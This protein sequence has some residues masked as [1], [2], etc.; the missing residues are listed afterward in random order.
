MKLYSLYFFSIIFLVACTEANNPNSNTTITSSDKVESSAFELNVPTSTDAAL[1][2]FYSSY[3]ANLNELLAAV[4][5]NDEAAIKT[6]YD[7]YDV[8]FDRIGA[9]REK[10]MALGAEEEN[11]YFAFIEQTQ[12]FMTEIHASPHVMK[13]DEAEARE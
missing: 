1:K 12:P 6:A 5:K 11:K 2:E 3:K 10:A 7:Q 13:L 9:M 8:N 4:R